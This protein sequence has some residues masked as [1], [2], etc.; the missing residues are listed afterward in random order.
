MEEEE[1]EESVAKGKM[2][3]PSS[4]KVFLTL[5]N[6]NILIWRYSM[7]EIA[8]LHQHVHDNIIPFCSLNTYRMTNQGNQ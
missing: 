4:S 2:D 1:V 5:I 8:H 3:G 7:L 6:V